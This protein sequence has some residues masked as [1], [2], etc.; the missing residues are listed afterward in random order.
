M[1]GNKEELAPDVELVGDWHRECK[2]KSDD[3]PDI[4]ATNVPDIQKSEEVGSTCHCHISEWPTYLGHHKVF[5]KWI[6]N[7]LENES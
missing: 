5:R 4:E 3:L 6:F 7:I 2:A 1:G